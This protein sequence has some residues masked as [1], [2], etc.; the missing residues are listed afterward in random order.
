MKKVRV[1][2]I[3]VQ[4]IQTNHDIVQ[5]A[6]QNIFYEG[7]KVEFN[8]PSGYSIMSVT[9]VLPDRYEDLPMNKHLS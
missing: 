4:K 9:E 8:I 5:L 2:Y 1:T 6:E 7:D 3:K